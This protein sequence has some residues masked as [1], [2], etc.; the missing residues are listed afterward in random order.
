MKRVLTVTFATLALIAAG[1]PQWTSTITKSA[2]G[3]HVMGNP[4]A[5]V[6]LI[7]YL[8]YTCSHCAEF[9]GAASAP[10][11]KNYVASGKVSVEFRN[12]VRDQ[13]DMTAALAARCGGPAKFFG[14]TEAILAAQQVW[15]AKARTLDGDKL[16][17]LPITAQL[18]AISR[19]LGFDAMLAKRGVTP[20][21]LNAC[22]ANK[23]S[24]QQ[25]VAMTNDAFQTRQITGTPGFVINN[26]MVESAHNWAELEPKLK[27]ALAGK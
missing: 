19:S 8:S 13:I 22:M 9:S 16:K 24:Q 18:Q 23:L 15:L 3:G 17:A 21:Q 6:K 10:L 1:A 5:K 27:S 25:V 26:E 12:A 4:N 11:K 20:V 7:E 14:N 2:I